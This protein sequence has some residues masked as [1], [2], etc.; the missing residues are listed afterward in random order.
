MSVSIPLFAQKQAH[1]TGGHLIQAVCWFN[2]CLLVSRHQTL[3]A[4]LFCSAQKGT[5]DGILLLNSDNP[6]STV[7]C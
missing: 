7:V 2:F 3:C 5:A 4:K 6:A 1:K